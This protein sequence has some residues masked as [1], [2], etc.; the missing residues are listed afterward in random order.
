[1]SWIVDIGLQILLPRFSLA[2]ENVTKLRN[3]LMYLQGECILWRWWKL[4][5][6]DWLILSSSGLYNCQSNV[7]QYGHSLLGHKVSTRLRAN[8]LPT[9]NDTKECKIWFLIW[10][11]LD[12]I[13]KKYVWINHIF[14][15]LLFQRYIE[16]TVFGDYSGK[17]DWI[18]VREASQGRKCVLR[19][20]IRFPDWE[21]KDVNFRYHQYNWYWLVWN[22]IIERKVGWLEVSLER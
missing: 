22:F 19:N 6:S 11:R 20:N 15:Y 2:V 1:M 18:E 17:E 3:F 5:G 14:L 4:Y 7:D 13:Q 8:D 9:T 16:R 21:I 12:L 10:K